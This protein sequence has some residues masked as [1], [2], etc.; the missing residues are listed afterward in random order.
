MRFLNQSAKCTGV[1]VPTPFRYVHTKNKYENPH[2]PRPSDLLSAPS[3]LFSRASQHKE[4]KLKIHTRYLKCLRCVCPVRITF[5]PDHKVGQYISCIV[6]GLVALNWSILFNVSRSLHHLT[7]TYR[8]S[9]FS[10]SWLLGAA[11]EIVVSSLS[12]PVI[13]KASCPLSP[14]ETVTSLRLNQ[15]L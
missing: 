2:F 13:F 7:A 10:I 12:H 9:S 6:C 8:N 4:R 11:V 14:L 15:P 5:I 3:H 1:C